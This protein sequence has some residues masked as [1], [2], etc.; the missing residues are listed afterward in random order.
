MPLQQA[1]KL[2]LLLAHP[3]ATA[4]FTEVRDGKE[5]L[6][7]LRQAGT[8]PEDLQLPAKLYDLPVEIRP[9]PEF[10]TLELH[11]AD[12]QA[13]D[14]NALHPEHRA[15]YNEP[16][17]AG[18]QIQPAG[19]PWVGTLGTACGFRNHNGVARWGVLSNWHVLVP[20]NPQKSHPIHQPTDRRPAFAHL[21]DYQPVSPQSPNQF[22]A[23]V[24]DSQIGDHH[25][26]GRQ[27]LNAGDV[28]ETIAQ[29]SVGLEVRKSGRTT[30]LTRGKIT[31][32]D[33]AVR[34]NYGRFVATF[35]DQVL[36]RG[37]PGQFGAAGDSGSLIFTGPYRDPLALLFAG[38][39]NLT[40]ASP[41]HLIAKRF[42]LT[43]KF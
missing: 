25:S 29:A 39:G 32:I 1:Q 17:P 28:G 10:K 31:A 6:I 41:I 9:E 33:A 27:I 11:L 42:K 23:A 36:I 22:D 37:L 19:A 12:L 30:G 34:V 13:E 21:S 7:V 38:G 4:V 24:A 43:F 26:V 2:A 18:T 3:A 16:I 35:T 40:I 15:C 20:S 8:P 5:L 14:P